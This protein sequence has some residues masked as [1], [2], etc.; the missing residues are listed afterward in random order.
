M[1]RTG[2]AKLRARAERAR[3][4]EYARSQ[5]KEDTFIFYWRGRKVSRDLDE[6]RFWTYR[7]LDGINVDPIVSVCN[8]GSFVWECFPFWEAYYVSETKAIMVK[9]EKVRLDLLLH[10]LAHHVCFVNDTWDD[11]RHR[12]AF[13]KAEERIFNLLEKTGPKILRQ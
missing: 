5:A 1:Q 13:L 3:D 9:S 6:A 12:S 8:P 7:I 2:N 4:K 10:E 11:G